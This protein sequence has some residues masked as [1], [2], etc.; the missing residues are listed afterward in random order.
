MIEI[1]ALD[2]LGL[3]KVNYVPTHF[4]KFKLSDRDFLTE[5]LENWIKI[6]SKGRYFLKKCPDIGSDGRLKNSLI[7]GFENPSELTHFI[8]ACPHLRRN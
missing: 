4:S 2:L 8:L 7:V 5:N 6:K 1:N 3:R